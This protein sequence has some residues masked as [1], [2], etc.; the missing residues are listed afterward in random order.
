MRR[1]NA[2]A[3]ASCAVVLGLA[4]GACQASPCAEL[5]DRTCGEAEICAESDGCRNARQLLE[6][7]AEP[8]CREALDNPISYPECSI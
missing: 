8:A 5:V 6:A 1:P 7:G 2:V 3:G 4:L